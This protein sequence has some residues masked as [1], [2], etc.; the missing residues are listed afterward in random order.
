V[1][2]ESVEQLACAG[3]ILAYGSSVAVRSSSSRTR[4]LAGPQVPLRDYLPATELLSWRNAVGIVQV[5]VWRSAGRK[6][7]LV[8]LQG[9]KR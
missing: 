5:A 3:V 1:L 2:L 7:G 4:L 8:D 6:P 9:C